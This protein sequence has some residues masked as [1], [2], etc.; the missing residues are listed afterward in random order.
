M[1]FIVFSTSS[2][3]VAMYPIYSGHRLHWSIDWLVQ[4]LQHR[5]VARENRVQTPCSTDIFFSPFTTLN[6]F[7]IFLECLGKR[8]LLVCLKKRFSK[9]SLCQQVPGKTNGDQI[10][11]CGNVVLTQL[12]YSRHRVTIAIPRLKRVAN[13]NA[14]LYTVPL[15]K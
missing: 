12:N 10:T 13:Y 3:S 9:Y 8:L 14:W 11:S 5:R 6:I 7:L 1:L 2:S 15:I 4:W